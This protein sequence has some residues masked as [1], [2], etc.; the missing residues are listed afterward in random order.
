[1]QTYNWVSQYIHNIIHIQ[2]HDTCMQYI[3]N[4]S[5]D[6]PRQPNATSITVWSGKSTMI[7]LIFWWDWYR[8]RSTKI[9][10]TG[11]YFKLKALRVFAGV[12]THL[13]AWREVL[14]MGVKN[15]YATK[16]K[17]QPNF[18]KMLL[19]LLV[20]GLAF[21]GYSRDMTASIV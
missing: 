11:Y 14:D 18:S 5:P 17:Y 13:V 6:K 15:K 9:L 3:I 21:T 19:T 7:I 2:I 12:V 10:V 20:L 16:R 8:L 4:N 1:M